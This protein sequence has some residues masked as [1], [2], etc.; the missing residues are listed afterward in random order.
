MRN[1]VMCII[2][3]PNEYVEYITWRISVN[4]DLNNG[5]FLWKTPWE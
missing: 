4:I 1:C 2:Y 5:V 3:S